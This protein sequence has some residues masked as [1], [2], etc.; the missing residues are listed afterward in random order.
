MIKTL[1]G[2][3]QGARYL[4]R[5][6]RRTKNWDQVWK[7]RRQKHLLPPL[8]LRNGF[9]LNHGKLDSPL[10]L[11]DEV[12]I[13]RWYE[14]GARPPLNATMLDIG[15]NIGSVTMFWAAMSPSLRIYAYEPNPSAF[16]TLSRN[17]EANSLKNR[18][19]IFPDAVGRGIGDLKLWVDVPTDLSTGY[20]NTSP[21][22]GGRRITVPVIGLDEVWRRINKET[23]WLLKIDT[24]GAEVDI[25][26]GASEDVLG[27]TQNAIVEYHDNIYPGAYERCR[28]VLDAAG[29]D[30]RVLVHPWQEGIIYCRRRSKN[31][32]LK[33]NC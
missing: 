31:P 12:Y 13:K 19:D 32:Q 7:Y 18:V 9:V 1:L 11:L 3:L 28:R 33:E 2:K 20:L 4:Y 27:A 17:V 22:E 23:I 5:L 21:S 29:F 24:E 30:C 26:E 16:E 6:I 8:H 25:L 14:I 10:L 15:A